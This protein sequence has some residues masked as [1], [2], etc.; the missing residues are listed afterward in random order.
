VH[1]FAQCQLG[2]LG[3]DPRERREKMLQLSV[4]L[5]NGIWDWKAG[6]ASCVYS[7]RVLHNTQTFPDNIFITFV[8]LLRQRASRCWQQ[9]FSCRV[10]PSKKKPTREEIIT[11]L[12]T[13]LRMTLIGWFTRSQP[14]RKSLKNFTWTLLFFSS[15]SFK[16]SFSPSLTGGGGCLGDYEKPTLKKGSAQLRVEFVIRRYCCSLLPLMFQQRERERESRDEREGGIFCFRSRSAHVVLHSRE[17]CY[18][19][20]G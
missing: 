3:D 6:R 12:F 19:A 9:E 20:I 5:D 14:S 10:V 2:F 15:S 16:I 13:K 17:P 4:L 8:G 7:L 11:I 18:L 1:Y